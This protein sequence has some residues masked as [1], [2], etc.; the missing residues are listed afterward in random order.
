MR[1][2][3]AALL[4]IL[5]LLPVQAQQQNSITLSCS[6]TSKSMMSSD[7]AKPDPVTN[8]GMIVNFGERTVSF[9]SYHIPFERIDNTMV[10]FHGTQAMSYAGTKLKPVTVDGSV[11]RVTGAASVTFMHEQ[12]G[13][14]STWELL[15][16]PATRLF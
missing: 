16:R 7:D 11:D 13:N 12:V 1:L 9:E 2:I 10:L 6:G 3:S 15:C 4:S 14:N 8:L 5:P